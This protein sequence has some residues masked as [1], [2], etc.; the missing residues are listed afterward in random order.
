MATRADISTAET[1]LE[2]VQR[3]DGSL[4]RDIYDRL[5]WLAEQEQQEH[6]L[7]IRLL[8]DKLENMAEHKCESCGKEYAYDL[9][10]LCSNC[11]SDR[12]ACEESHCGDECSDNI[13]ALD[14]IADSLV[15][16][17]HLVRR[18]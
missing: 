16:F 2:A 12:Y 5:L 15:Q 4:P 6:E 1:I 17:T 14:Q 13:K 18:R 9:S 11:G 8:E 3:L 10:V 7:A